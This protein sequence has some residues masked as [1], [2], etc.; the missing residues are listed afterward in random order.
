MSQP[1]TP[2]KKAR[3]KG[4][5]S[6]YSLFFAAFLAYMFGAPFGL[7]LFLVGLGIIFWRVQASAKNMAKLPPLPPA[8]QDN[9]IHQTEQRR[10]STNESEAPGFPNDTRW[11][12]SQPTASDEAGIDRQAERVKPSKET[13]QRIPDFEQ[14]PIEWSPSMAPSIPPAP[15]RLAG[16]STIDSRPKSTHRIP[17]MGVNL[18]THA[19]LRHAIVAMTV[20]G[21][22]RSL[23][24]Y[25]EDPMH[26]GLPGHQ[27]EGHRSTQS[28]Q[29][30]PR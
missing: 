7:V 23:D 17:G 16:R 28:T 4:Q 9:E 24:P 2:Q 14:Q 8:N 5:P 15:Q 1:Q 13:V 11:G 18:A 21:P 6:P 25:Q 19:G 20:L 29:R 22:C 27:D 10:P 12:R 30:T 3:P 26:T